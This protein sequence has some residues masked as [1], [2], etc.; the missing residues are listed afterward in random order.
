M[1]KALVSG[2]KTQVPGLKTQVPGLKTRSENSI[3]SYARISATLCR[4]FREEKR[5]TF[6]RAE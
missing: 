3:T 2:L 4:L 1:L 5:G 6:Y